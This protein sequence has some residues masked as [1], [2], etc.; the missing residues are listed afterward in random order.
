MKTMD[1]LRQLSDEELREIA[2]QKNS[3]GG[4]TIEADMAQRVRQE[5]SGYWVGVPRKPMDDF[6][7]A[8]FEMEQEPSSIKRV[9][10]KW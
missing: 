8:M 10:R 1:E 3:K 6:E 7:K 9:R 5:R 4:Y 2:L